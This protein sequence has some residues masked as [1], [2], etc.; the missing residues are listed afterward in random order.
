MFKPFLLWQGQKD[1]NPRHAV[2]ERLLKV[3]NRI[4]KPLFKP[5]LEHQDSVFVVLMLYWCCWKIVAYLASS[6]LLYHNI[7]IH[8]K[9]KTALKICAAVNKERKINKCWFYFE[10]LIFCYI[11]LSIIAF[12]S[13]GSEL[14]CV[15]NT[16][17]SWPIV[18]T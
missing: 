2:L 18:S 15:E 12:L 16:I 11:N 7:I 8:W 9:A 3:Q 5:K 6:L 17:S 1:S 14:T 4:G 10:K 13:D